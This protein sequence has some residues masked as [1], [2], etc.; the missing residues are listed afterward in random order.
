M[1][2]YKQLLKFEFILLGFL[3]LIQNSLTEDDGEC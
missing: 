1:N 2:L 3:K